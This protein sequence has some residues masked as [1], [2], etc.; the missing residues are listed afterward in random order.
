MPNKPNIFIIAFIVFASISGY[1]QLTNYDP[2]QVRVLYESLEYEKAVLT[3][4]LL[5]RSNY[6]FNK[7]DLIFLHEYIALSFYNLGEIDSSRSH[8]LSLLSIHPEHELDPIKVSPKIINFFDR[9]KSETKMPL[10]A[11]KLTPYKEYVFVEDVRPK[12]GLR[13]AL[14]PGLGQLYKGQKK[15]GLIIGG[16]F[17]TSLAATGVSLYFEKDSEDKYL[18]STIPSNIEVNYNTYDNWYKRRQFFTITTVSVWAIGILDALFT[19]YAGITF[20]Q[21]SHDNLSLTLNF[22][23][24]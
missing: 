2:Q 12:A 4:N 18:Q 21:N 23:L 17:I 1:S 5:L 15:K 3:G 19:P 20:T 11:T 16:L 24:R 9:L 6:S 22:P 8:F 10:E 7:D 14:L 13:S